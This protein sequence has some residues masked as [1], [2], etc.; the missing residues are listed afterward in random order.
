[1]DL[2]LVGISKARKRRWRRS[3]REGRRSGKGRRRSDGWI[4]LDDDNIN[5]K[6]ELFSLIKEFVNSDE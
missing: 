2:F 5:R 6:I 1:M 4:Y 3:R